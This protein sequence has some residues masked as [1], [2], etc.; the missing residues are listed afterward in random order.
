MKNNKGFA[1]YE[2]LTV[3]VLLICVFAYL[4][5]C[6]LGGVSNQKLETFK[7]SAINFQKA[8][9]TNI[10]TFHN[11][12]NVYLGEVIDEKFL[13]RIKNPFGFGDC[14]LSD[15]K[16]QYIDSYYYVTLKC[17]NYLIDKANFVGN[18]KVKY[19]EVSNWS[20]KKNHDDDEEMELFNC[21]E[22]GKEKYPEYYE[23]L[24]FVSLINRDFDVDYYFADSVN[25]CKVV[26]KTFYRSKSLI[27]E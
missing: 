24:Y 23:E 17:G 6:L 9:S 5:Y 10:N 4:L 1:K 14:S 21:L 12:E 13:T 27:E 11:T 19:Y 2:V 25:E 15:S 8:V 3:V 16:V 18:N 22:N 20:E 26:S 7:D